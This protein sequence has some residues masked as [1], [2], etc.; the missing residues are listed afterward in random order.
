M[1]DRAWFAGASLWA[2]AA[3]DCEVTVMIWV[4][5]PDQVVL[6]PGAESWEEVVRLLAR[7]LLLK[8]FVRE[9]Y[10]NAVISRE[11]E[12]PTGLEA[13]E[14]NV[15]VPHADAGHVVRTS[16][17]VGVLG[18]P[19]RFSRMDEPAK[20]TD[21][22]VVFLLAVAEPEQQVEALRKVMDVIHDQG[23]LKEIADYSSAE[24]AFGLLSR[25]LS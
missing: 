20:S 25:C 5:E 12:Y 8:G 16:L 1:L 23:V 6:L 9:T 4:L 2:P 17:C 24:Q 10:V 14:I 7:V 13:G 3:R 19:V 18:R 21:V 22:T 11:R 15:A